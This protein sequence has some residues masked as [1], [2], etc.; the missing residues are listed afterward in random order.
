MDDL[1]WLVCGSLSVDSVCSRVPNEFPDLR[2]Q[3]SPIAESIGCFI[4]ANDSAHRKKA[5]K[6]PSEDH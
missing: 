3:L 4:I 2:G 5:E 1:F 6:P